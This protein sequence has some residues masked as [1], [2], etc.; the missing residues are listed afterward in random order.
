[1]RL[2]ARVAVL[3]VVLVGVAN[4]LSLCVVAQSLRAEL[5]HQ[6]QQDVV[7]AERDVQERLRSESETLR[8]NGLVIA[9]VG[10][11][12]S[13][14]GTA[15]V[16]ANWSVLDMDLLVVQTPAGRVQVWGT[17]TTPTPLPPSGQAQVLAIDGRPFLASTTSMPDGGRV[18]VGRRLTEEWIGRIASSTSTEIVLTLDG[19]V[20]AAATHS[21]SPLALVDAPAGAHTSTIDGVPVVVTATDLPGRQ[22]RLVVAV[23]EASAF[24]KHYRTLLGLLVVS[25][26]T[27]LG[28]A[29]A[30][31]GLAGWTV[32]PLRQVALEAERVARV[33]RSAAMDIEDSNVVLPDSSIVEA[34]RMGESL[35]TIIN[36][37]RESKALLQTELRAKHDALQVARKAEA[38]KQ[39]FLASMSHELRTPLNAIIG[40]TEMIRE[41]CNR[42][43]QYQLM[44]D[45]ERVQSASRY[46]LDLIDDI[47]A[48]T[49]I[50]AGKMHVEPSAFQLGPVIRDVVAGIR[51]L[52]AKQ[53]NRLVIDVDE[54]G[55]MY[56]DRAK[57]R[58]LVGN[59]VSNGAKFTTDGEVEV[60]AYRE[61]S[62]EGDH[63]VIRIRDSGIGMTPE[64]VK[65]VFQ[66]FVLVDD[67]AT[68][69]FQGS[70]LGLSISRLFCEMLLGTLD[71]K[72]EVDEGTTFTVRLPAKL[73]L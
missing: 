46:L 55:S 22:A 57:I 54:A 56:S 53:Y 63:V 38:A 62:P 64:Q 17:E 6:L 23:N 33:E 72:S 50:E 59:L 5:V 25:V 40:Y 29:A 30:A 61:P 27:V 26:I 34:A 13:P 15:Y 12:F 51:P 43:E 52:A 48:L 18:T 14:A 70:G 44:G 47:L 67:S 3:A 36:E 49:L 20:A 32:A 35:R 21:I 10:D 73:P 19:V 31:T 71:V 58:Q 68:R 69:R 41:E 7:L 39:Q 45:L 42:T 60:R 65:L 16:D 1:M 66:A 11:V 28:A 9:S 37:L 4:F 2:G 8:T 24:S